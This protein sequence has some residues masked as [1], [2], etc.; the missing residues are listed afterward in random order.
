MG[1]LAGRAVGLPAR[2]LPPQLAR[3]GRAAGRR[4]VPHRGHPAGDLHRP[5]ARWCTPRCRCRSACCS[6]ASAPGALLLTGLVLMTA[7]QLVFAFVESFPAAVLA[8]A[9]SARA[10]RWSSSSVIRLVSV[11]FL[12]RQ[13][14]LVTQLTGQ[15]G[16]LGAIIAAAPLSWALQQLGWTRT[17]ALAVLGRRRADG[18]RGR[19]WSRTRRTPA[20][21]RR[22]EAAGPGPVACRPCGATPGP[23]SGCGRTSPRSS[24]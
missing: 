17:F 21:V 7:G 6:T 16:Q 22:G 20:P 11:W 19:C 15:L 14:P 18:R 23:G 10:T 5:A 12:V 1:H 3:R 2:G 13:A 24:R 9:C 8:R 4:P